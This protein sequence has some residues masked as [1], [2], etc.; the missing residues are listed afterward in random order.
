MIGFSLVVIGL[1]G[2]VYMD[3]VLGVVVFLSLVILGVDM[4]FLF[5]WILCVDI[6]K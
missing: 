1:I 4:I 6:G 2:S 3:M 5:F